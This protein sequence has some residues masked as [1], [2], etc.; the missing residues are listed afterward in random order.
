MNPWIVLVAAGLCEVVW[1]VGLKRF[2]GLERPLSSG[3][4]LVAMV[5]SL[6]LLGV[7]LRNLPLGTAYAVWVGIGVAGTTLVGV[8]A[9]GDPWSWQ[10]AALVAV[11]V[12][13]I[14][15]LKLTTPIVAPASDLGERAAD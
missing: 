10:R 1:A 7:A 9:Q 6:A 14:V 8:V 5:A 12:A 11:L 13:A 3:V 15:G 4:T 2:A